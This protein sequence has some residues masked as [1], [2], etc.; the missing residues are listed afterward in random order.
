MN[1]NERFLLS[2]RQRE[3][4]KR[5][6]KV[7]VAFSGGADSAMLLYLLNKNKHILGIELMAAAHLN[8][9]LRGDEA[10]KDEE[11][12]RKVCERYGIYF[13]C[14]NA[15]QERDADNNP[16]GSEAWGR[17]RRREFFCELNEKHGA[18]I[19]TGHNAG[20]V[21][22][23]VI[24]RLARGTGIGGLSGISAKNDFFVRPLIDCTREEIRDSAELFGVEYRDDESNDSP[25]YARNLIRN[26]ILP[27]LTEINPAAERAVLRAAS[28][29]ESAYDFLFTEAK[30]YL[31]EYSSPEVK[32]FK[33]LHVAMQTEVI[34]QFISPHC[35]VTQQNIQKGVDVMLRKIKSLNLKKDYKLAIKNGKAVIFSE[36]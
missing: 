5:G 12:A 17:N 30:K 3:L 25:K 6:D 1:I 36:K 23:T 29:S 27:L 9:G 8:H 32:S 13:H 2:I 28:S 20:D 4:L 14:K 31:D 18:I 24:F 33:S 15:L 11:L 35:E 22:E 10:T 16:I 7:I 21:A 26:D 34:R 19:A